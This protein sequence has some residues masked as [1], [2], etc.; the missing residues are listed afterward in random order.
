MDHKF[1]LSAEYV[2]GMTHFNLNF[3]TER[4]L[5]QFNQNLFEF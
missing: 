3:W 2:S 1:S 5:Q 4:M